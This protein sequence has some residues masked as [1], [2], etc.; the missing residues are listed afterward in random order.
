MHYSSFG[1]LAEK[2]VTAFKPFTLSGSFAR[3]CV[4]ALDDNDKWVFKVKFNH[5]P[6][7]SI[8]SARTCF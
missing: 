2:Y 7:L 4:L 3:T 1:I 8:S 6:Q 5:T